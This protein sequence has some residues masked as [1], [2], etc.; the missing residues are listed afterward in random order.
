M[1]EFADMG[2]VADVTKV[3][4]NSRMGTLAHLESQQNMLKAFRP[5]LGEVRIPSD[6]VHPAKLLQMALW[7]KDDNKSIKR[8]SIEEE[9][10]DAAMCGEVTVIGSE[11]RE[12]VKA[13]ELLHR[14]YVKWLVDDV[15]STLGKI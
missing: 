15:L 13:D 4:F 5:K 12:K 3:M 6:R 10:V 9:L 8:V 7:E 2:T 1:R 14:I 11:T